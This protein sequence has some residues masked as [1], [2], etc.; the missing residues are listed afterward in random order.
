MSNGS[1]L[2]PIITPLVLAEQRLDSL[3]HRLQ[4]H[5]LAARRWLEQHRD[6]Q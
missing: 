6:R 1:P 3:R 5:W 4:M 2:R